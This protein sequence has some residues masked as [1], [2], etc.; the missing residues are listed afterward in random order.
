VNPDENFSRLQEEAK[1]AARSLLLAS[2]AAGY[3]LNLE[4]A[5]NGRVLIVAKREDVE[6]LLLSSAARPPTSH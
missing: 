4:E 2:G 6:T 1:Q 3:L 5:P